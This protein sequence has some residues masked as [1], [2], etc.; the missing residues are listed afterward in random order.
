MMRRPRVGEVLSTASIY[1]ILWLQ[2]ESHHHGNV[3]GG[4]EAS[5]YLQLVSA[6]YHSTQP[7]VEEESGKEK[8]GR[9]RRKE[10]EDS[11]RLEQLRLYRL[12]D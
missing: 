7:E 4:S 5:Q 3:Y 6:S 2:S 10:K 12:K 1:R 11:W 8:E 9:R